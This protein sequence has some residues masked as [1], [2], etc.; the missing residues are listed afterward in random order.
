MSST[1]LQRCVVVYCTNKPFR[2]YY[3][4][5][6][7]RLYRL[8]EKSK[9]FEFED[10][11]QDTTDMRYPFT[12]HSYDYMCQPDCGD[13]LQFF[14]VRA[15]HHLLQYQGCPEYLPKLMKLLRFTWKNRKLFVYN[16]TSNILVTVYS[17]L[18][19]HL[20]DERITSC[21]PVLRCRYCVNTPVDNNTRCIVHD[22]IYWSLNL[23]LPVDIIPIILFMSFV[24]VLPCTLMAV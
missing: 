5:Q 8:K 16:Q 24:P 6:H 18:E 12:S 17:I 2:A 23:Q 22:T 4:C 20:G 7:H 1:S 13:C 9:F 14:F 19:K 11:N 15:E 21:F 3:C 10:K